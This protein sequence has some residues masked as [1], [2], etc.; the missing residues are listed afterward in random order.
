MLFRTMLS[1]PDLF[2]ALTRWATRFQRLVIQSNENIQGTSCS[3][4]ASPLLKNRHFL[5]L[6]K[7]PF[8]RHLPDIPTHP[9]N[10]RPRVLFF[11]GCLIDKIL[12][13]IGHA[14]VTVLNNHQFNLVIPPTQGCCGIPALASGDIETFNRLVGY[15]L[16]LF[17]NQSF[18]YLVTACATCTS[19]IKKIWPQHYEPV[20]S[21]KMGNS[22]VSDSVENKLN[23]LVEKTYDIN[24][25][26]TDV[27]GISADHATQ[28]DRPAV[29]YHDPCHLKKS[30]G[31]FKQ[32]RDLIQAAGHPIIEMADSDK[33]CGMGGSFNIL[34][35]DLSAKIGRLKQQQITDT[36]CGI[37]ASGCPACMMQISDM[38]SRQGSEIMVR[39]PVELYAASLTQES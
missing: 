21:K 7:Q 9:L 11:S 1:H 15:H 6:S 4:I 31:V 16:E 37:V 25:F 13:R 19:T 34:H 23:A 26:L 20:F 36:Q 12:P 28:T 27:A 18:D 10:G 39:H 32:P 14:A 29:T 17:D 5:P 30:L 38:L 24:E 33:C 2:N 35:Y 3:K 22:M 8:H